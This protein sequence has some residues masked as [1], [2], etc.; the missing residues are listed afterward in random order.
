VNGLH[1][2]VG[3]S[4]SYGLPVG[5]QIFVSHAEATATAF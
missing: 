4:N 5:A 2:V 3:S 1:I